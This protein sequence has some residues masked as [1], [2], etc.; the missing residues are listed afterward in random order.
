MGTF[1][2]LLR[3][4]CVGIMAGLLLLS[5]S[6]AYASAPAPLTDWEYR[7]GDASLEDDAPWSPIDFP[8]N[9]PE[10]NGQKSVWFKTVLPEGEWRDPVLH[11]TSINLVGQIY[12]DGTLIYQHGDMEAPRFIGWPWHLVPL[13][14]NSAGKTLALRIHSDYT[15]IGLWGD[16]EI[17]DRIDALKGML[18]ASVQDLAV[19]AFS[20]LLATLA[21]I[22]AMIGPERRGFFAIA[23]F[24]FSSGL[25]LLAETPVRQLLADAPLTW[26]ILRA[27]SYFTLPIA[28]GLMLS[29]WLDGVPKRW[30]RRLWQLHLAYLVASIGLV[31]LGV[32][33]LALTFPIFDVLLLLTLP[34]ML[35][36]ALLRVRRL[37]LEQRLFVTSFLL[38]APLLL[39]DMLVAHELIPRR[40][41]P[42]SYGA[43]GF[44]LAIVGISLWHYR[45]TQRQL[46]AANQTLEAQVTARTAELDTLV[47]QLKGLSLQDALTGLNN[48]RHFDTLL[49][50]EMALAQRKGSLLSLLMIDI[51][52][53]KKVND[54]F[55]HDAGDAVLIEVAALL[56]KHF[57]GTDVVCRLGGEEFVA[58]LPGTGTAEAQ[59]RAEK[60]LKAQRNQALSHLHQPLGRITLSCGI[61][62]YPAHTMDPKRLLRLADTALYKAK[63]N[64][65][66]RC[67]VWEGAVSSSE[68]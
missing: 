18:H 31:A 41:V 46:A 47:E 58:L 65:R 14:E 16:V 27:A 9:P 59:T 13:P 12:L 53:F 68:Q 67:E 29:H 49:H 54:N 56:K 4:F 64:G 8:S 33:N 51:D 42:L 10:R 37:N 63:N 1:N 5:G 44:S 17:T 55:G 36:L 26:D 48:R 20:L 7:W 21:A 6:S 24:A 62:T 28:I 60:L 2:V 57:R 43:L 15:S 40:D 39:L 35:L 19:S 45:H 11:I 22:F 61:A 38:F 52:H 32:V 66:D 34:L 25:M 50:Q 23:L 3:F 30:M